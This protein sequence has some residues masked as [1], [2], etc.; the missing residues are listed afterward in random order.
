MKRSRRRRR[1]RRTRRTRRM[2][3]ASC[4]QEENCDE[5]DEGR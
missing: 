5:V 2:S 1:P 4:V 3:G